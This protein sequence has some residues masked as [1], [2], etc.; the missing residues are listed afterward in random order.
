MLDQ[1]AQPL[2]CSVEELGPLWK[3]GS[4]L[5]VLT[6][7]AHLFGCKRV[8]TA[9]QNDF[10]DVAEELWGA[11]VDE[12]VTGEDLQHVLAFN[13]NRAFYDG[14]FQVIEE[15]ARSIASDSERVDYIGQL[16]VIQS[17]LSPLQLDFQRFPKRMA[18]KVVF[19][20][21]QHLC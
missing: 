12:G 3:I 2:L 6:S 9:M 8:E 1:I 17:I 4:P 13:R 5:Q 15:K 10:L 19:L 11:L 18:S 20:Q 7:L 14:L 21:Q 16:S